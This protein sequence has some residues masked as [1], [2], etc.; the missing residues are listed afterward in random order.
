MTRGRVL[1]VDDERELRESA[2]EWLNVVGFD[3]AAAATAEEALT[4]LAGSRFDALVTD[5][6]MPQMDGLQ[7]LDAAL[8][9]EPHLPVVLL[10]GH[11]DVGLAVEAMRR[12]AHDFLEKPY[13][14]DHLV[15]VLDRAV[16]E[17]RLEQELSRLR[18]ASGNSEDLA[19]RL[20]G[21][22]PAIDSAPRTDSATL[23]YRRRRPRPGR[24]RHRQGGGGTRAAR[25]RRP[26]RAAVR[27]AQL[28]RGSRKRVR[29]RNLRP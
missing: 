4:L 11:G 22:A 28:R 10:T 29:K 13:D 18:Q 23:G 1:F 24:N 17:R 19:L 12:G 27:G 15:A 26:A 6:R 21:N 25:F 9:A 7:L 2:G 5:V 3:A 14:A 16:K 8:A 20:A